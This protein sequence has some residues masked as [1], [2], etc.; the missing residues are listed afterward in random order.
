MTD[1]DDDRP[2][3]AKADE[4]ERELDELGE[5]RDELGGDIEDAGDQWER[6]K[7]DERVPG[8]T[9]ELDEDE[10]DGDGEDADEL[11]F[12][13]DIESE[14]VVGDAPRDDSDEDDDR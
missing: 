14:D 1:R 11:D 10:E 8:A 7:R 12:G 5:R 9:G 2:D 13:R 3:E 4:V 6:Q